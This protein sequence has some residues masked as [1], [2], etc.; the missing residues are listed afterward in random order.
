MIAPIK[1]APG[2]DLTV[3]CRRAAG[4]AAT[5][6]QADQRSEERAGERA[7][8]R[9]ESSADDNGDGKLHD[10]AAKQKVLETLHPVLPFAPGRRGEFRWLRGQKCSREDARRRGGGEPAGRVPIDGHDDQADGSG[11]S[12]IVGFGERNC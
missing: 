4:V 8:Q 1:A 12:G 11:A 7:D 6:Q 3:D 2:E 5:T 10:I 9:R